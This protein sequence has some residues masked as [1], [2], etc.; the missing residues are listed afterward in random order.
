MIHYEE[1]VVLSADNV[2][3]RHLVL[4]GTNFVIGKALGELARN[5]HGVAKP[6]AQD[7]LAVQAQNTYMKNNYPIFRERMGGIAAAYGCGLN[8]GRDFSLLGKAGLPPGCSAVYY[9]PHCTAAGHGIVN[10]NLDFPLLPAAVAVPAPLAR[11]YIMEIYPDK[12]YPSLT[13]FSFE[14]LGEALEGINSAGLAV[15]HLADSES[16]ASHRM[17]PAGDMAVGINELKAVQLLLDTCGTV[18]DAKQALLANKHV[19]L[20]QPI[21][22]LI[23]DCGGNSFVWEYSHAHNKEYII[24]GNDQPQIITN[25]LLHRYKSPADIPHA[26]TD[27]GCPYNRYRT[28]HQAIA[29]QFPEKFSFDFIKKANAR[30]FMDDT[31]FAAPR[32]FPVRTHIN[33]IYDLDERSV[34]ISFYPGDRAAAGNSGQSQP[35]YS[36]YFSFTLAH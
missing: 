2:E 9:P 11:P 33:S 28:L 30:V 5:R 25:F 3:V 8:E 31:S 17:E 13:I 20:F 15:I 21:H 16:A 23:A 24:D 19:Y 35:D 27:G 26:G 7:P 36:P 6:A 34:Q 14:L 4:K 10:R 22:L 18:D 1:T 32:P 12:G 29:G